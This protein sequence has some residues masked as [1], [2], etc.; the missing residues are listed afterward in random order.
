MSL[1]KNPVFRR[2]IIPWY[3]SDRVCWIVVGFMAVTALFSAAG[4]S[5]A[6]E[7]L[8]F[9]NYIWLPLLLILLSTGTAVAT[10]I[11]MIRRY[12]DRRSH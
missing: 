9:L 7:E 6:M 8:A 10:L 1:E 12:I 2:A 4:I 3:D 5:V 11:R